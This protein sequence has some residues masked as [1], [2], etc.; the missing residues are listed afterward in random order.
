[1]TDPD[2]YL[3]FLYDRYTGKNL[4]RVVVTDEDVELFGLT[5]ELEGIQEIYSDDDLN[6]VYAYHEGKVEKPPV[7]YQS[8]FEDFEQ[9]L[10]DKADELSEELA[11]LDF[12]DSFIGSLGAT[13]AKFIDYFPEDLKRN[14]NDRRSTVPPPRPNAPES[15]QE[16]LTEERKIFFE[17]IEK[18]EKEVSDLVPLEKVKENTDVYWTIDELSLGFLPHYEFAEKF[19]DSES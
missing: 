3:L 12:Y 10:E 17:E 4:D 6:P 2:E 5:E 13:P 14:I 19:F 15:F 18:Y 9:Q 16:T 7:V 11:D 8:A 1:M